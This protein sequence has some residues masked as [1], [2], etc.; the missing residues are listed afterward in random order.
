MAAERFD[1]FDALDYAQKVVLD[2]LC[3]EFEAEFQS[4]KTP[5]ANGYLPRADEPVRPI[6]IR[7]LLSIEIAHRHEPASEIANDYLALFPDHHESIRS[8]VTA[9]FAVEPGMQ[10]GD[11][12]IERQIGAGGMGVVYEAVDIKLGRRVALKFLSAE[13][14][15]DR[16]RLERFRREAK[17]LAGLNHPHIA[18]LYGF[19]S[20]ESQSFCILEFVPGKTLGD[21]LRRR[22]LPV[23]EAISIFAQIAEALESA[24]DSG[25]IHRDLKPANIKVTDE[26]MVK[27]LESLQRFDELFG[28]L[29]IPNQ[30]LAQHFL[31]QPLVRAHLRGCRT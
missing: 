27:V 26:G 7:E 20:F 21:M 1:D 30:S 12:R 17:I 4:G 3:D 31:K 6:L 28:V 23:R 22:K 11:Y 2:D 16:S 13:F 24:H 19:D 25:V 9:G 10:V 14:A 8:S 5:T 18:T 29:L 15:G